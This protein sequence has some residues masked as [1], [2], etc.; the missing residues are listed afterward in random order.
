MNFIK[1]V[2]CLFILLTQTI[3]SAYV[4]RRAVIATINAPMVE[5]QIHSDVIEY[6]DRLKQCYQIK[7][8]PLASQT[9]IE[10]EKQ[11]DILRCKYLI[12]DRQRM[13]YL[14]Y[15]NKKIIDYITKYERN[16]PYGY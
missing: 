14:Y 11:E 16:Y 1:I 8:E 2:F 10:R 15:Q 13:H 9:Q 4:A 6:T 5:E 3:S 7:Y 12:N